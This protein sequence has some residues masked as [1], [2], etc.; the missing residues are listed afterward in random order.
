MKQLFY[1]GTILTLDGSVTAQAMLVDDDTIARIGSDKELLSS[2]PGAEV[3]DLCG[4]TVMPSFIDAHSHLSFY[5]NSLLQASLASALS[6]DD[7]VNKLNEFIESNGFKR[8]QWVIACGYDHNNLNEKTHPTKELLDSRFP[9][10]KIV[11]QHVSGHFGVFSSSALDALGLTEA[12][13]NGYL[14]ENAYI[15]AVK[16]LPTPEPERLLDAYKRAQRRYA[17]YGVTTVQEGMMVSQMLELYRMLLANSALMLDVVGYPQIAD[18]DLFYEAFSKNAESYDQNFRLGGYKII[19]D[20]SPQGRTAWVKEPYLGSTKEYGVSSMSDE[21]VCEALRRAVEAKRQLLAHCNGDAAAEQLLRCAEKT[22]VGSDLA[23]IRPVIVHAQLLAA[24]QLERV[25]RLG[26]IPSFFVAHCYY[27]GDA[28][29]ENLGLARAGRISLANSARRLGIRFTFH[30]DAP[31]VEPDM[32]MTIWCA[33]NRRTKA[34]IC[35][36]EQERISVSD[37]IKAITI[38]AAYQY[39][40]ES[41]KGTLAAGKKADFIILDRNPLTAAP[42]EVKE[43]RVIQTYKSGKSLL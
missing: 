42:D 11:L 2:A 10:Y 25:K 24:E 6:F 20:G 33:A 21:A 22:A 29:I 37:A 26:F 12:D 28:H 40:E 18:A 17:S 27:W 38:D 35:L 9:A 43:V 23:K 31:V 13:S 8:G 19:L 14:E 1:N 4:K 3:I 39:G 30:Q 32:F 7:I 34:G 5:A 16:N 36:G 15:D 41:S